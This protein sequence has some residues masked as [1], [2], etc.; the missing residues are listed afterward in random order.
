LK[1]EVLNA[2]E[3]VNAGEGSEWG[4]TQTWTF[5][6]ITTMSGDMFIRWLGSSNGYYGEGVDFIK[7]IH[8][9]GL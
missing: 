7:E 5:Y 4:D 2:Y 9:E 3:S 6:H 1:G 8:D